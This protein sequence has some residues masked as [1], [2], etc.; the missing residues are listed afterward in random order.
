MPCT[1][2]RLLCCCHLDAACTTRPS[3]SRNRLADRF[4]C[5]CC[6]LL[7]SPHPGN[8]VRP[9]FDSPAKTRVIFAIL[10]LTFLSLPTV[11]GRAAASGA[12]VVW[13]ACVCKFQ[14]DFGGCYVEIKVTKWNRNCWWA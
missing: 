13:A 5:P 1:R 4:L 10:S 11:L 14:V 9:L 3:Q 7:P 12:G 6:T 2:T 8:R